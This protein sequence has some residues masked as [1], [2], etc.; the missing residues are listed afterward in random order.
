MNNVVD[1]MDATER[2]LIVNFFGIDPV[3]IISPNSPSLELGQSDFFT[4]IEFYRFEY[5]AHEKPF[6]DIMSPVL[7]SLPNK[8][9]KLEMSRVDV[10]YDWLDFVTSV[11]IQYRVVYNTV[12]ITIPQISDPYIYALTLICNMMFVSDFC[13]IKPEYA[14]IDNHKAWLTIMNNASN[15]QQ[16][17]LS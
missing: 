10:G 13:E 7:E 4:I 15:F 8:Q 2:S 3:D 14:N 11:D 5:K 1:W 12:F 6:W 17:L 9:M 16:S